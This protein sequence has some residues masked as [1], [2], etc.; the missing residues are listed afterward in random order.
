MEPRNIPVTVREELLRLRQQFE[1]ATSVPGLHHVI[2]DNKVVHTQICRLNADIAPLGLVVKN[3]RGK[4]YRLLH[5]AVAP[6][7]PPREDE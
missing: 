2:S 6:E 3:V 1:D 5:K 7:K 4:G